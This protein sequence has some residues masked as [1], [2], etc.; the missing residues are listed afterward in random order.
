[1][2]QTVAE[3]LAAGLVAMYAYYGA[4]YDVDVEEAAGQSG[5]EKR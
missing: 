4:V 3:R 2:L 1:M 5:A